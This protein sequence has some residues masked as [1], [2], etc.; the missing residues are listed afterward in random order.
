LEAIP[1]IRII[2]IGML[3][4]SVATVWLNAVTGTGKTTMNLLIELIAVI[5][6]LIYIYVVM[7]KMK[8]SL[9]MAWTNEFIYWAVIF[10]ISF[11][12]IRSGRW[13][14]FTTLR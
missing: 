6:Y 4:M 3:G 10:G 12:Y 9:T 14:S 5:S 7:I 11:W 1:V 2:S 8:L 13:K